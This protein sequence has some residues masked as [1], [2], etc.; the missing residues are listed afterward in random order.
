MQNPEVSVIIPVYNEQKYLRKCLDSLVSQ[1]HPAVEIIVIDDGSTDASVQIAEEYVRRYDNV[2]LLHQDHKG[3]GAARNLGAYQ[4]RG[5]ILAFADADMTFA[6]NYL[7]A[8]IAPFKTQQIVGT[9][10]K[11][12]YVA[13]YDNAWARCWNI[14]D[15]LTTDKRHPDNCPDQQP[16]F[17]A[18]HKEN[19][20]NVG[21]FSEQGSG[22]DR[23]LAAKLGTLARVA[24]GA[25]CYHHNPDSLR[26][27]FNQSRWY[28]RG[29]RIPRTWGNFIRHALPFSIKSSIRRAIRHR[30]PHFV[31]FKI[32]SDFGVVVGMTQAIIAPSQHGK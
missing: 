4:V 18:V 31:L 3:P 27:I 12:E 26:D 2:R 20:L 25:V 9:F 32:V 22:D 30:L 23:T 21:G 8:L 13:N 28:A 10:S 14:N 5:E 11:E 6:P 15:G 19:F 7:E 17:R 29:I 24:P 16:V 1:S